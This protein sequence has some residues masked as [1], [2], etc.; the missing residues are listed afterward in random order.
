MNA[1]LSPRG[2]D[3]G[4]ENQVE[5]SSDSSEEILR[6]PRKGKTSI[7][8][9]RM[10]LESLKVELSN[11]GDVDPADIENME[12]RIAKLEKSGSKH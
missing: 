5:R 4:S 7:E 12:E 2:P 10:T 6:I 11:G 9:A 8:V 3:T 1:R